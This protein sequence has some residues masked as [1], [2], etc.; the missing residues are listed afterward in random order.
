MLEQNESF[1]GFKV[2]HMLLY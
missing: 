2:V 1:I